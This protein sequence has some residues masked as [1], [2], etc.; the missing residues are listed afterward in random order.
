MED[1][2]RVGGT[3]DTNSIRRLFS[4]RYR[5][6]KWH[7]LYRESGLEEDYYNAVVDTLLDSGTYQDVLAID[8]PEELSA[9]RRSE[10]LRSAIRDYLESRDA[11]PAFPAVEDWASYID[12]PQDAIQDAL[13]PNGVDIVQFLP[14]TM[15]EED[16]TILFHPRISAFYDR[17]QSRTDEP[18]DDVSVQS[19]EDFFTELVIGEE[20]DPR[21]SQGWFLKKHLAEELSEELKAIQKYRQD[22]SSGLIKEKIAEMRPRDLSTGDTVVAL[23]E[24]YFSGLID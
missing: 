24:P 12:A 6:Q 4:P 23:V 5:F 13:P 22:L 19:L 1:K 18:L 2:S 8:S 21:D 15:D 11:L 14:L 10:L 20:Q 9:L 7:E 16:F 17:E 3:V